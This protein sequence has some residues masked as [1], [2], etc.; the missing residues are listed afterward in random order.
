MIDDLS[1]KNLMVLAIII[2]VIS[3]FLIVCITRIVIY[4]NIRK[5]N[6]KDDD[7]FDIYMK[8]STIVGVYLAI[9]YSLSTMIICNFIYDRFSVYPL[10]CMYLFIQGIVAII[11]VRVF[12]SIRAKK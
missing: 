3:V 9:L 10:Y 2:F 4:I 1:F 5:G 11:V 6:I 8:T 12:V 7:F